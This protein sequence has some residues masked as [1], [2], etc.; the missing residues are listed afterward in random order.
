MYKV[1]GIE[2]VD[3]VSKK[4]GNRVKGTKLHCVSDLEK[5][6]L[7][8]NEV[9]SFYIS[10]VIPLTDIDVGCTVNFFFNR[11]GSVSDVRVVD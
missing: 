7:I 4:T 2:I 10:E 1:L 11:F 6:N 3:Y 9:E 5:D 8:G